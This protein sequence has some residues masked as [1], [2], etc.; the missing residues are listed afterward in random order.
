MLKIQVRN[1]Q[2]Y[3]IQ[4]VK[5]RKHVR[6][7]VL[8]AY[9]GCCVCCGESNYGFLTIDH[10]AGGGRA[11]RKALNRTGGHNFCYWLIQNNYP[12]GFR[13]LCWNC[14]SGRACNNGICPHET[15]KATLNNL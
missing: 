14:N 3:K 5:R 12:P 15:A 11:H 9:G 7:L 4:A 10:E 6:K 1:K 8:D 2:K 13:I